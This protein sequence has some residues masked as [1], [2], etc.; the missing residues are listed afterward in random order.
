MYIQEFQYIHVEGAIM[1]KIYYRQY[2]E[3]NLKKKCYQAS[4]FQVS[5]K[6]CIHNYTV[7]VAHNALTCQILKS[8]AHEE[9]WPSTN[10]RSQQVPLHYLHLVK[11]I[12]QGTMHY[13]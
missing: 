8:T 2:T 6:F 12:L 3:L 10:T 11:T 4:S 5:R 9:K 1:Y 7:Y 13:M